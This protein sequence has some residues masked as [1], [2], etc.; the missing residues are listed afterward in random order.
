MEDIDEDQERTLSAFRLELVYKIT[1]FVQ[2]STEVPAAP[3]DPDVP[4]V[5]PVPPQ[6]DPHTVLTHQET[7]EVLP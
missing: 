2:D 1:D 4:P 5:D 6:P 3:D 7:T